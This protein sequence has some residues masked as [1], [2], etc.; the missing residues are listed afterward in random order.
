MQRTAHKPTL[1]PDAIMGS[2]ILS[3]L[4]LVGGGVALAIA[5]VIVIFSVCLSWFFH[6]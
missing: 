5:F 2:D 4:V 1:H 3:E 6:A